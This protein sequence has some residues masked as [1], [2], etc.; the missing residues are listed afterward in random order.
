[1]NEWSLRFP[2]ALSLHVEAVCH[3][4][5]GMQRNTQLQWLDVVWD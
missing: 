3:P 5:D 1:M 2:N 4:I